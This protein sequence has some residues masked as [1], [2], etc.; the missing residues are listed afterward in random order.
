[1]LHPYLAV[2][3]PELDHAARHRRFYVPPGAITT[4]LYSIL[5]LR[6]VDLSEWGVEAVKEAGG[7]VWWV[8]QGCK[9]A[10][11]TATGAALCCAETRKN[12]RS[13]RCHYV[14]PYIRTTRG[15]RQSPMKAAHR[16]CTSRPPPEM[17]T[18]QL[19]RRA[20]LRPSSLCP[21]RAAAAAFVHRS[22]GRAATM[23]TQAMGQWDA[24]V[25]VVNKQLEYYN[26]RDLDKFMSIM[27]D[28]VLAQDTIT[29]GWG[30]PPGAPSRQGR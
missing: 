16:C 28:D 13:T 19:A 29:G 5:L 27:A 20:A 9:R 22:P 3:L 7:G 23:A 1:M 10:T 25:L 30:G 6:V 26:S 4:Q 17:S 8:G 14:G 2:N 12:H 24:A 11:G 15:H 21:N 18:L